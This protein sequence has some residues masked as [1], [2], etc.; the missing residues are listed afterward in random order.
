MIAGLAGLDLG[1][2]P[3][4]RLHIIP[5]YARRHVAADSARPS[6]SGFYSARAETEVLQV[7]GVP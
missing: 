4:V 7:V 6:S 2:S 1:V 5:S 3:A